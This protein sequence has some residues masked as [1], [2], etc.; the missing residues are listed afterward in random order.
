MFIL[1]LY[2]STPSPI[3]IIKKIDYISF[4]INQISHANNKPQ[5]TQNPKIINL[6]LKT[7]LTIKNNFKIKDIVLIKI[8]A[9]ITIKIKIKLII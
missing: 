9:K 7:I 5:H 8:N 4:N 3:T 6:I 1:F 2:D